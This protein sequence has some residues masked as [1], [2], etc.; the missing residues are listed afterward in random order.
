MKGRAPGLCAQRDP[1]DRLP[2]CV[3][4]CKDR[5]LL[6]NAFANLSIS[7]NDCQ[8]LAPELTG[9]TRL[10]AEMCHRLTRVKF[11]TLPRSLA[12][13]PIFWRPRARASAEEWLMFLVGSS[14][15][16]TQKD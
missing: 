5:I 15:N 12:P 2:V 16:S 10:Q 4:V 1:V 3:C 8:P 9:E 13:A 7:A 14:R 6:K 11:I